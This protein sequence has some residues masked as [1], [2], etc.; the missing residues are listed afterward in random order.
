MGLFDT[1][2]CRSPLPHHRDAEFQTT[3]LAAVALGERF[4][5]DLPDDH[6]IAADGAGRTIAPE[7]NR[8]WLE[9]TRPIVEAFL[10]ARDFPEMA[11]RYG[12]RL[13]ARRGF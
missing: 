9:T 8:R 4:V 2:V 7:L 1:V 13:D 5:S 10:H 6:E 11:V 3:D 12:R